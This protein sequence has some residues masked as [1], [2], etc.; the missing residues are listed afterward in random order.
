MNT[1][2]RKTIAVL[3]L[4]V[5]LPIVVIGAK[6]ESSRF[7][8]N[9]DGTISDLQTGLMWEKK[10]ASDNT[11]DW[12]NPRDADSLFTWT[13]TSDGDLGNPMELRSSSSWPN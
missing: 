9:G 5:C 6:K 2:L 12:N 10:S 11:Q 7:V 4:T 1:R 8:D 13:D 3:S